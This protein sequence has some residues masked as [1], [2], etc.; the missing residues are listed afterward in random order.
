MRNVEVKICG[1]TRVCDAEFA[2]ECGA[3]YVGLVFVPSSKRF[4]P[5]G[6]AMKFAGLPVKKVGV[7]ADASLE[8]I[9]RIAKMVKLDVIQLHGNE[10]P[11]FASRIDF[12]PVWKACYDA[13]FP[14]ARI[15]CDAPR[16]GS[17]QFGDHALA[18]I[19]AKKR[20]V[21]LAGGITPENAAELIQKVRPAGIDLAGGV[22]CTPG[23]KDFR[24]I[25][26]LFDNIRRIEK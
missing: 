10:T 24:L 5:L 15:V 13:D 23:I 25:R 26:K 11:E 4:L 18:A 22:E 12:A 1:I 6:E 20:H 2:A 17:G 16:G 21:M 7:F 8:E 14:A 9:R 3:D 19:L